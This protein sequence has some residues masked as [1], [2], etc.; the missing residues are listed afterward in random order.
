M[1]TA[2]AF[3][4]WVIVV[5]WTSIF[6]TCAWFY[7]ANRRTFGTTRLLLAVLALDA[8]R[9]IFE[10]V[11]FGL[12]FG[13]RYGLFPAGIA[14]RLGD[15]NLLIVPKLTN[16]AAGCIL[17]GLLFLR[18]LPAAIRERAETEQRAAYLLEIATIDGMTRLQ[19]RTE[20]MSQAEAEWK[21]C[22]RYHRVLTLL[23]LD[24]RFGHHAGDQIIILVGKLCRESKRASDIAGRIGGEEFAILLPETAIADA[25][26]F[27]ERLRVKILQETAAI[28]ADGVPAT[29]SI[30]LSSAAEAASLQ[31]FFQ[32]ADTALYDAKR[33]GRNRVCRFGAPLDGVLP[34]ANA[35]AG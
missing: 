32:Q 27:A 17:L 3:V 25:H 14:L 1:N 29:V 12:Y 5:I 23:F 22:H 9:N 15:P 4:Y 19:N 7:L 2:A 34:E 11:Y 28:I 18:W 13:S 16:V 35:Q 26:I 24:D 31:D 6:L 8:L 20:F 30:G 21:R 10:N 33:S